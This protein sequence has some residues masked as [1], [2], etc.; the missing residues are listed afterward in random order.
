VKHD[1][2][3]LL[4]ALTALALGCGKAAA[5]SAPSTTTPTDTQD[6][7]VPPT[8]TVD[9]IE[10]MVLGRVVLDVRCEGGGEVHVASSP[11]SASHRVP[12]VGL[13]AETD[14]AC[15]LTVTTEA[16][17]VDGSEVAFTTAALPDVIPQMVQSGDPAASQGAYTLFNHFRDGIEA[18]DQRLLMV[19]ALGRTRW[20]H[21][22]GVDIAGDVDARWIGGDEVLW[23]GGY[24]GTPQIVSFTG[25]I[26]YG[27][28]P[29]STGGTYHHHTEVTPEGS[30]LSLVNETVQDGAG[31]S[32]SGFM[33][34][35]REM[36]TDLLLWAWSSQAA[37]DAGVLS[38]GGTQADPYHGNW[39]WRAGEVVYLAMRDESAVFKLDRS[40][41]E[42]LWAFGPGRDFALVD[43]A[44]APA[45]DDL[46]FYTQ[47]AP[48]FDGDRVLIYDNGTGRPGATGSRVIE[49]EI[50]EVART[51]VPLW[52][53]TE[54]HWKE[55][56]WGDADRM[57][58]GNVLVAI[59]HCED[60]G[61]ID[62]EGRSALV[63]L[64]PEGAGVAWRIDFPDEMDGLYRAQRLG[65]CDVF[66]NA[67][68]CA[69]LEAR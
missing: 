26:R 58:G 55:P 5:D 60:C 43:A 21:D 22:L 34:E 56:I 59:G 33:V 14:Y 52:S 16:G 53:W 13:L 3:M 19:D 15:T 9:E 35:E 7:F 38:H 27:A 57:E 10:G 46:W 4:V 40:T 61:W 68:L 48:E 30:L 8:V 42:V 44:G 39:T 31:E 66:G 51:A 41:G 54:P 24:G 37:F 18:V 45:D 2:Q 32:W 63:E 1:L 28:P 50:D 11:S 20:Y 49:Y 17:A 64:H 6:V 65:P 62:P 25:E 36:S 67:T 23:G 29:S 12:V 47:H 69:A